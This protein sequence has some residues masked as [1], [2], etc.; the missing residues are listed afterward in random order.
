MEVLKTTFN[1]KIG[2]ISCYNN[3]HYFYNSLSSNNPYE[4]SMIDSYLKPFVLNSSSILDIGSHIGY[5]SV[6]YSRINPNTRILAFEPQKMVFD[7]LKQNIE[8]NSI[9]NVTAFNLAVS[10]KSG[11]FSLSSSIPDGNN[12]NT[13]IE[14]GTNKEFN[15]GGVSLGKNGEQIKT[16][17][18]DSLDLKE[19]DFVKIDV[20]G[21]E[22]L[23]IIGGINTIKKY[24][25]VICYESNSKAIT[26]DMREMFDCKDIKTP[27]DILQ[28]IGYTI[29]AQIPNDNFI[30]IYN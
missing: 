3:D 5:H 11:T 21:A 26:N 29:F 28:E 7:L 23:V 19:L 27:R 22:P 30:A 10:N 4:Q 6:A 1:T 15:L 24:K 9:N 17:T 13:N 8:D 2:K 12:A 18:I 25:P 20:E 14:Y 16:T